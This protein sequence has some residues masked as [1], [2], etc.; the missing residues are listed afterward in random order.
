LHCASG[1]LPFTSPVPLIATV[2]DVAWLRVQQH[3]RAY[4]R[5]YFGAF[6]LARYARARALFVDSNFSRL[7]LLALAKVDPARLVVLYPGV[8]NDI[9]RVARVPGETP[10]LLA[11]GTVEVRKNLELLV[12]VVAAVPGVRLISVGPFTPYRERVLALANELGVA[13]RIE[14]RGYVTRDV[15]L[16]LYRTATLAAVPSHYEGFGYGAAQ[17]LCAGLPLVAANAASLPE[18]VMDD[19]P[20]VGPRDLAGWVDAV[21][22]ILEARDAAEQRAA[23]ARPATCARLGWAAS[24]SLAEATYRAVLAGRLPSFDSEVRRGCAP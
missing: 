16:E 7:E 13:E 24:A 15:L 4:A 12:R 11:V 5:A 20:L 23:R 9:M 17:A 19:A 14:L 1:T 18:I 22:A 3:A 21:R 8:A 10:T 6:A 2:H